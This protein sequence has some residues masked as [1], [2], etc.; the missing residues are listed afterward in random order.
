MDSICLEFSK[1]VN[2]ILGTYISCKFLIEKLMKNEL[3]EQMVRWIKN[4]LS[5]LPWWVQT[6][7]MKSSWRLVSSSVPQVSVLD[8]VLFSI[9]T[10]DLDDGAECIISKFA[11][12]TKLGGLHDIDIDLYTYPVI[13]INSCEQIT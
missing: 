2:I 3:D 9:F 12:N 1:T 6:S 11:D 5:G 7:S 10:N 13:E 8:L 4:C